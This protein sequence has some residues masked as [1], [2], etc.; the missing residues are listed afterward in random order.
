MEEEPLRASTELA[1]G[2]RVALQ[3]LARRP[4]LNGRTGTIVQGLN[5]RGRLGVLLDT[6]S[7]A[8]PIACKPENVCSPRNGGEVAVKVL[9]DADVFCHLAELLR[10]WSSDA[11]ADVARM[12]R[13]CSS[14]NRALQKVSRRVDLGK[15]M[16][17]PLDA[18]RLLLIEDRIATV[19]RQA[20][21]RLRACL[22]APTK[23][24]HCSTDRRGHRNAECDYRAQRPS[25]R[26]RAGAGGAQPHVLCQSGAAHSG[27]PV[28]PG[29]RHT[30]G[31]RPPWRSQAARL[32]RE[33]WRRLAFEPAFDV[34]ADLLSCREAEVLAALL[35]CGQQAA[36]Q[37]RQCADGVAD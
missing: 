5:G 26:E 24:Q 7:E 11:F 4:D 3:G 12:R 14:W 9:F 32:L 36:G 37:L 6:D 20:P 28:V 16:P 19:V 33:P 22:P 23:H 10:G 29:P 13:V 15:G 8:A 35:R 17:F 18:K 21:Q 25:V 2:T 30:L 1:V 34:D 31:S 27:W